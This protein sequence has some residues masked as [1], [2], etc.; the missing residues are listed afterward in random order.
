M[1]CEHCGWRPAMRD[2]LVCRH[3]WKHIFGPEDIGSERSA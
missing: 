1:K 2:M 3:C